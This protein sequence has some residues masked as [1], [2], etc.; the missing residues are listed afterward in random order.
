MTMWCKLFHRAHHY[1]LGLSVF[2]AVWKC[3]KCEAAA[4]AAYDNRAVAA[5]DLAFTDDV[6]PAS[7]EPLPLE[8]LLKQAQDRLRPV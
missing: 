3:R 8:K 6:D 7:R 5:S 2:G 1:C 4:L